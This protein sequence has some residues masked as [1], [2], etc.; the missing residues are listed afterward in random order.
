MILNTYLGGGMS[1]RLFQQIR[2]K[3]GLAYSIYSFLDFYSDVGLFGIYA[4]TDYS[5]LNLVQNLIR[6]ELKRASLVPIKKNTLAKL[7][8][9]LKGNLILS[10]E[11]T[12]RRMSRL[13][14]NEIYFGEYQSLNKL[15][16]NIDQV[17]EE[18]I[19]NIANEILQPE[20]FTTVILR[21]QQ[22]N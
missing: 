1:S 12:S 6:D 8:N 7:K 5:N 3:R 15:I 16:E 11:S 17:Q 21:P 4:G 22:N 2:E 9:Q 20:K 13:A 19:L 10:L 18:D 14:R